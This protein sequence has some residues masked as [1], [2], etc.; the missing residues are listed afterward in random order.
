MN[1]IDSV[2]GTNAAVPGTA[3]KPKDDPEKVKS[4]SK[5]FEALLI[6]QMLKSMNDSEGGWLGTGDD[7]SASSAMQYAT[8][9]FAQALA[10]NGGL[11][12]SAM[13]AKG[14]AS[15]SN[16]GDSGAHGSGRI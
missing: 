7:E 16:A 1:S 10:S 8:E 4:A 15:E 6:G 2:S 14:L 12:I 5:Q 11:G 9:S 13:V 3:P